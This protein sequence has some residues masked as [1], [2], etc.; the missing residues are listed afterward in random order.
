[1]SSTNHIRGPS[2]AV[3]F[4]RLRQEGF[5]V[6]ELEV[7]LRRQ[8]QQGGITV[9]PSLPALWWLRPM[10][11]D[12]FRIETAD[13]YLN[14]DEF[15]CYYRGRVPDWLK[16]PLDVQAAPTEA[17]HP[18]PRRLKAPAAE[19]D[20]KAELEAQAAVWLAGKPDLGSAKRDDYKAE[21]MTEFPGLTKRGWERIRPVA[22]RKAG[23]REHAKPGPKR[24]TKK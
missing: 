16:L 1:M 15:Y 17:Q 19:R 10:G 20:A 11:F 3:F 6:S 5:P 4:L 8:I 12:N 23:L 21:C 7:R 24:Q 14:A 13:G 9:L 18:R 2:L 22:R